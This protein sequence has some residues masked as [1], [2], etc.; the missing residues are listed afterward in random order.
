[1]HSIFSL[2]VKAACQ[3]SCRRQ[4]K[5]SVPKEEVP[6]SLITES[7][8]TT[9]VIPLPNLPGGVPQSTLEDEEG[10]AETHVQSSDSVPQSVPEDEFKHGETE[11]HIVSIDFELQSHLEDEEGVSEMYLRNSD[12]VPKRH[13][14]EEERDVQSNNTPE[15]MELQSEP[16]NSSMTV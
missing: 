2:K 5:Q 16:I 10:K 3:G 4:R 1:M 14:E 6:E 13:K 12:S 7:I 9:T 15:R 11:T 8:L